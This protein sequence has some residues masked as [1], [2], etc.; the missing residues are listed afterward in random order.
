[1]AYMKDVTGRR[2]DT[3]RV[4]EHLTVMYTAALGDSIDA[5]VAGYWPTACALTH[6]RMRYGYN[7]GVGGNTTTQALARIGEIT[8]R[9]PT[10]CIIGGGVTNDI[11]QG[12]SAATTR[13]NI[14]SMVTTL[15]AAGIIPLLRGCPPR[16]S[17]A[18]P[19]DTNS[20]AIAAVTAHN[21]W[22]RTYAAAEGIDYFDIHTPLVDTGTGLMSSAY[23]DD[24]IH[25]NA[26]GILA[27][28]RAFRDANFPTFANAQPFDLGVSTFEMSPNDGLFIADSNSD[29]LSDTWSS[30]SWASADIATAAPAGKWQHLSHASATWG[31]AQKRLYLPG[32]T[33]YEIGMRL[34]VIDGTVWISTRHYQADDSTVVG[35]WVDLPVRAQATTAEGG[36]WVIRGVMPPNASIIRMYVQ[37]QASVS[38][39][40]AATD[41]RIAQLTLRRRA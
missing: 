30:S 22:A 14:A 37:N 25:P 34:A 23:T 3:F 41:F 10:V 11:G 6:Q 28:A 12:I 31:L 33:Y 19:Y 35:N 9:R 27:A 1:M 16:G 36:I 2:L 26:A 8:T 15:K 38:P 21:T 17:G 20:L 5:D 13:D 7:G 4:R 24:G 29:G 40:P 39:A 32:G 18:A